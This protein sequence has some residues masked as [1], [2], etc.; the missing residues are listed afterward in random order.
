MGVR[1]QDA[2]TRSFTKSVHKLW[3]LCSLVSSWLSG[4]KLVFQQPGKTVDNT[5]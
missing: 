2:K 5:N 3:A 4:D 1:H